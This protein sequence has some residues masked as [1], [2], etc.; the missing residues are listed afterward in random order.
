MDRF[1]RI[2]SVLLLLVLIMATTG[3]SKQSTLESQVFP[4]S[5]ATCDSTAHKTRYLV[6]KKDGSIVRVNANTR[7][8]MLENYVRPKLSELEFVESD[9][10][11]YESDVVDGLGEISPNALETWGAERIQASTAWNN[12]ITGQGVVVA[13]IDSGV[14]IS[15][16][17]LSSKIYQ[18][19]AEK[20]G[21]AGVDDD[22][23]GYVDDV[24]GWDFS[25]ESP[26]NNDTS[27]H[28]THVAGVIA[29]SHSG[30]PMK[31]VAPNS[32]IL[33]L[34]FMDGGSGYT[35]DAIE[36]IEYAKQMGARVI[37]ASWG[38]S[39]CSRILNDSIDSLQDKDVLF[40]AAAGNSGHNLSYQPEYPA[41]F[42]SSAQ[43][44]VGSITRNGFMSSFSNYGVLVDVMA[45][46]DEILSTYPSNDFA[47][48]SGTSMAAPFVSGLAAL[49]VSQKPSI[50]V[51]QL[52]SVII[53]SVIKRNYSVKSQGEINVPQAMTAVNNL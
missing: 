33:P 40:V 3:C 53:S 36:A 29:G 48:L 46:G 51:S 47:Y 15:H 8:E 24:S 10:I 37:N 1:I 30:G 32:K 41:A 45:P 19:A 38:S 44:T 6:K 11:V 25:V 26:N 35:S 28:G 17:S 5:S 7:D 31:G 18:N 12:N 43:I 2:Y 52:K 20:N 23:N 50:T 42:I 49:L 22:N 14:Q 34:D 27:G 39:A 16:P 21:V 13:V 4:V 9:Q